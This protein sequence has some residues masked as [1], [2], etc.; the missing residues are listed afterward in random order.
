MSKLYKECLYYKDIK[1]SLE[2]SNIYMIIFVPG[3]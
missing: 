2:T 1:P 3:M